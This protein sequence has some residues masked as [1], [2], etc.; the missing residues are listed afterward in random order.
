MLVPADLETIYN[1]NPLYRLGINGTGQTITLVED[2]DTYSNDVATYRN[3]FL[4]QVVGHRDH[5]SSERRRH[6]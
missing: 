5:H 2:S 3:T 6:L 4:K 1:L